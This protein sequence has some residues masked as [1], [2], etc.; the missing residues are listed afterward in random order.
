MQVNANIKIANQLRVTNNLKTNN[1]LNITNEV[2]LIGGSRGGEQVVYQFTSFSDFPKTAK[3]NAIYI[4]L[5]TNKTYYWNGFYVLMTGGSNVMYDAI[6]ETI[7][8]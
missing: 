8:I 6:N 5:S 4:D 3:K 1:N 7:T 2:S